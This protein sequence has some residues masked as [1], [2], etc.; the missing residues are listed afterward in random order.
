MLQAYEGYIE[1]GRVY[2]VTPLVRIKNRCRVIVTVLDEP[3]PEKD[4]TWAELDEAQDDTMNEHLAAM[5]EFIAAVN[6]S[7]EEVPEF[8][9]LKLSEVE[10]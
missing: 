2:T 9:R 7:D 6:A 3:L 1:E 5:D 8:E 4:D 10:I